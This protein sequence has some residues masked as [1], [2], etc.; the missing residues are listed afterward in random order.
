MMENQVYY[1]ICILI[2]SYTVTINIRQIH[3]CG[4]DQAS[5]HLFLPL[6]TGR[7]VAASPFFSLNHV[8]KRTWWLKSCE[9]ILEPQTTSFKWMFGETTISNVKIWNHPIETTIYKWLN[10]C[11]GFQDY[12]ILVKLFG[13]NLMQSCH[14]EAHLGSCSFVTTLAWRGSILCGVQG[15]F[16]WACL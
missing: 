5:H 12:V 16:L 7:F 13:K 10:G 11:L 15:L 14:L 8:Q 2:S 6:T 9:M 3:R 1:I 4:R